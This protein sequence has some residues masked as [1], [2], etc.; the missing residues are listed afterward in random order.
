MIQG[1]DIFKLYDTY[2]FP[3]ELTEEI[4]SGAGFAV[5]HAGFEEEMQA[6]RERARNARN[7][8][9]SMKLQS[10]LLTEVNV[11]SEY[12]G[13]TTLETESS[14]SLIIQNEQFKDS[15][16]SGQ[17]EVIFAQTPF[18]AEMGGQV[19]DTGVIIDQSGETCAVVTDVQKAP[20]GQYLHQIDVKKIYKKNKLIH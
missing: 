3:V 15:I 7:K 9:Q 12:V 10:S 11:A 1:A 6:Q 5:D 19:A 8:E 13:Y 16:S 14:L 18:Y 20:K 2:G 17:A 4:A